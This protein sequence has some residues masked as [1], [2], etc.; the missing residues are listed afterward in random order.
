MDSNWQAKGDE[1]TLECQTAKTVAGV[2]TQKEDAG[3]SADIP[4]AV[5]RTIRV[6]FKLS[7][8]S[9]RVELR[10]IQAYGRACDIDPEERVPI[11]VTIPG[12][13]PRA[14]SPE[15][16]ARKP[17]NANARLAVAALSAESDPRLNCTNR[18]L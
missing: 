7:S 5:G 3:C 2:N 17:K 1:I 15:S 14:G 8:K 13:Q 6:A 9:E 10:K 12:M 4:S 18:L 11:G 16:R